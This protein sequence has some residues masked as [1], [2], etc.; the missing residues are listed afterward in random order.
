MY[1]SVGHP[2]RTSG[3]R[4][5]AVLHA[6]GYNR[7]EIRAADVKS[8]RFKAIGGGRG[9]EVGRRAVIAV[10]I[11]PHTEIPRRSES[12]GTGGGGMLTCTTLGAVNFQNDAA[13]ATASASAAVRIVCQSAKIIPES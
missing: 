1:I 7:I 11:P 2:V 9:V 5:L 8:V 13:I 3:T 4:R 6:R 10:I 12:P